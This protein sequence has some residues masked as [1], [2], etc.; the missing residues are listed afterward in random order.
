LLRRCA[1]RRGRLGS[2]VPSSD[3]T[4][5]LAGDLPGTKSILVRSYTNVSWVAHFNASA[6]NSLVKELE[7]VLWNALGKITSFLTHDLF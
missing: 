5:W 4:W 1:R 6:P 3:A 7:T 2:F